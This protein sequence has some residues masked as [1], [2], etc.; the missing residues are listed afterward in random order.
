MA[1]PERTT[2]SSRRQTIAR[3]GVWGHEMDFSATIREPSLPPFPLPHTHKPE[4]FSLYE[5]EPGGVRPDRLF[6]VSGPQER[7]QQHTVDQIVDAVLG[8]PTLDAPVLLMVEQL[9]DVL[10]LFDG[11]IPVAEQVFEVPKII[12]EKI[13]SRCSVREPQLAEQLVDV[14]T[15][16]PALVP[17]PRME[18]QLVEVPPIVPH[19]VPQSF[20]AGT[21]GYVWSQIFGPPTG[22]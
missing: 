4:L 20:F 1:L 18:D 3:A 10:Q 15:T 8:L 2:H 16:S 22:G 7:V 21:G 19:V 14:P 6:A 11:L 9:V 13:P 17:A 12:L 5:E